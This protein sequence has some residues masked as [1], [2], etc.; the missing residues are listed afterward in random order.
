MNE[1]IDQLNLLI[2]VKLKIQL[3]TRMF[4]L[5]QHIITASYYH[6]IHLLT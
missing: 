2:T 3:T 5:H 1:Y 6:I 4:G